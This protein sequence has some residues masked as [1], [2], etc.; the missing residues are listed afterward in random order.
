MSQLV[1][2]DYDEQEEAMAPDELM[3]APAGLAELDVSL[4]GAESV[5]MK[6]LARKRK[7]VGGEAA[8]A[9][10]GAEE[11]V[12]AGDAAEAEDGEADE[13]DADPELWFLCD[14]CQ[15]AIPGGKR[16]FECSVCE[17]YTLCM[18]CF[19]V[20]RHPHK[21]VRKKIPEHCVPPE[22]LKGQEP[23]REETKD[24]LDEYF[25]LDYEDIIGGD[26]PT[27]FK[28]RAVEKKDYGLKGHE[29]LTKPDEELNRIIP[30]KKLRTYRDEGP[31]E[32]WQ[33]TQKFQRRERPDAK[34]QR[35]YPE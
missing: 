8:A 29:I 11:D 16:Y 28:Y 7:A 19:R 27:R 12:E 21:F 14:G 10:E 3:Q 17:D 2:G 34:E 30:L 22:E 32:Q 6:Q 5:A 13:R 35:C 23:N 33:K 24:A 1:G 4:A 15:R 26:L 18:K 31:P 9:G 25:Q 20:R